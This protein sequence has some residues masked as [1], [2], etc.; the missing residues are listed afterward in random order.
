MSN[1]V[2]LAITLGLLSFFSSDRMVVVGPHSAGEDCP[3]ITVDC[4]PSTTKPD[5][6]S[7]IT[8]H[9]EGGKA[10]QKLTFR[11]TV[12]NGTIVDGQGTLSIKVKGDA[13]A[14]TTATLEIE[15]LD[16]GCQHAVSCSWIGD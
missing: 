3:R 8:V 14:N 5:E 13:R 9:M 4:S 6:P 2:A 16:R 7:A 15:G 11:W 10:N 1:S 12:A